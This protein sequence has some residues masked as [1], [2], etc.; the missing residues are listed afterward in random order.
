[1][2]MKYIKLKIFTV[3]S[4]VTLFLT[5]CETTPPEEDLLDQVA[6]FTDYDTEVDFS[7]YKTYAIPTDTISLYSNATSSKFLT[8]AN[9]DYARPVVD[10]IKANMNNRNFVL[11]KR[12]ENPDLGINVS[13]IH[14]YNIYQQVYYNGGY[15]GGYYGYGSS[16]YYPSYVTTTTT[17]SGILIVEIVDLKN[18][19]PDNKV[20]VVWTGTLGDVVNAIHINEQS[21]EGINQSFVQSPFLATE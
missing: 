19:T 5:A 20:K 15:G 1:M 2:I 3:L 18:R 16:Y 17:N 13:L 21:V 11:K 9:S 12:N 14:D 8:A 6:V 7:T 4:I 10:A